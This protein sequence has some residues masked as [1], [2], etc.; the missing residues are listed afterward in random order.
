MFALKFKYGVVRTGV[1]ELV[2]KGFPL[3]GNARQREAC[4]STSVHAY[5]KRTG[6]YSNI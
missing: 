2:G 4:R 5:V 6:S 3:G 1:S